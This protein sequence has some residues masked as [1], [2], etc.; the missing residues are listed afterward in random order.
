FFRENVHKT[1]DGRGRAEILLAGGAARA[2]VQE[3]LGKEFKASRNTVSGWITVAEC[4][5]KIQGF[6]INGMSKDEI[7]EK[8][9][10]ELQFTR[11]QAGKRIR[12]VEESHDAEN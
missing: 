4:H 3:T 8:L 6:L 7:A 9:M 10:D 11:K 2:E 5:Q 1:A 12:E